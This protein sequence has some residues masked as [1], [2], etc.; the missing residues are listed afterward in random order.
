[1]SREFKKL[2]DKTGIYREGLGFYG[3]RR[4]FQTIGEEAG[5]TATRYVMGHMDDD[6]A[7]Q[8]RQRI[9]NDR[10]RAVTGHVHAW[11]FGCVD[12]GKESIDAGELRV[13]G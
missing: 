10:L 4:G 1:M 8:Y 2:L 7:A 13:V 11:L 9:S 12:D 3:L 6:M 5:E